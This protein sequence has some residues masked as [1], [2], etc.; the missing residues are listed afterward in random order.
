MVVIV[1]ISTSCLFF[2]SKDG[3]LTT[4][5]D[6]SEIIPTLLALGRVVWDEPVTDSAAVAMVSLSVEEQVRHIPGGSVA[7]T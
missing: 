4:V 1:S 3:F 5:V 7:E 6:S 2:N